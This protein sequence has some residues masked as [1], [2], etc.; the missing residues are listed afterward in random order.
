MN[1][2]KEIFQT[3]KHIDKSSIYMFGIRIDNL[4]KVKAIKIIREFINNR[5]EQ[6]P[7]KIFFVNVHTIHLARRNQNFLSI[8]NNS[9]LALPDGSGL[10]I[11]GKIFS[12][13]IKENLNGTDLTPALLELAEQEG[14]KVYLLGAGQNIVSNCV[15]KLHSLFPK[16]K[17]A[18]FHSGYFSNQE[19]PIILE[20]INE[21]FPEILLVAMGSP[22]QEEFIN[23]HLKNIN[24]SVCIAVGG[25][26]DFL[27]GDKK[28]APIIIRKIGMEW[29]Y[30]F[31]NDPKSKW[32]RIFIEIPVFLTLVLIKKFLPNSIISTINR[33]FSF[34]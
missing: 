14:W 1:N 32:E 9:D 21:S 6:S 2:V 27:S 8:V 7:R 22:I 28:R 25:L 4:T 13:P 23:N 17:I 29:L 10:K 31:A 16:L 26:F 33:K 18:G 11:A 19:L 34:R 20:K 3:D 5:F 12:K 24:S 30:R 15:S